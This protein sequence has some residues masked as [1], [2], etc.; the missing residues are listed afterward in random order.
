MT[1]TQAQLDNRSNQLNPN[2]SAYW[3]SRSHGASS[4]DD[5]SSDYSSSDERPK[6]VLIDDETNWPIA[7]KYL[8][9]KKFDVNKLS[10]NKVISACFINSYK[11]NYDDHNKLIM[12]TPAVS[13]PFGLNTYYTDGKMGPVKYSMDIS[14]RGME[15]DPK[16]RIFHDKMIEIDNFLIDTAVTNSEEWFGKKHSKE[17]IKTFYH[18]LVRPS[19]DPTKYAPSMRF[20]IMT[21]NGI[22]DVDTCKTFRKRNLHNILKSGSRVQATIEIGDV[23]FVNKTNFGI[24]PKLIILN[25]LPSSNNFSFLEDSDD[26]DTLV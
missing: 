1:L 25:V 14:F 26:E 6:D 9:I 20:K 19:K 7:I 24:I 3:Q 2:N 4:S 5:G 21:R 18:P 8:G 13:A 10:V 17:V 11:I 23:W 16:I 12:Q 22:I 15:L